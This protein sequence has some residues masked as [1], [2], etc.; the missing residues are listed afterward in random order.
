M[1]E[2]KFTC[3]ACGQHMQCEKAYAGDKTNCPACNAELRVP[4]SHTPPEPTT[5]LPRAELVSAAAG[6][7][8]PIMIKRSESALA[9]ASIPIAPSP[10]AKVHS[11]AL[12]DAHETHCICPVCK[13]E[14]RLPTE[15]S[16]G[17]VTAE[18]VSG[19]S[20]NSTTPTQALHSS[21][22]ESVTEREKQIAAARESNPV[23]LYPAMKPRLAYILNSGE[24][25]AEGQNEAAEKAAPENKEPPPPFQTV[26]E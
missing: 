26:A 25:A 10:A 4:F 13:S 17:P 9:E 7:A 19:P 22:S 6:A 5:M 3:P 14:L 2:L 11:P 23:S 21:E 1:S 12:P 15:A 24:P 20:S 16:S 18:V 8:A